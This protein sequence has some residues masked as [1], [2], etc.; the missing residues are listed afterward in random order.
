MSNSGIITYTVTAELNADE[1]FSPNTLA[2]QE[3]VN[4]TNQKGIK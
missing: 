2:M 4:S 1:I 3:V